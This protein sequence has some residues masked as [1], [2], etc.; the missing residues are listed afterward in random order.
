[1]SEPKFSIGQQVMVRAIR[2]KSDNAVIVERKLFPAGAW[3]YKIDTG[4]E[5]TLDQALWMYRFD[6]SYIAPGGDIPWTRERYIY[7]KHDGGD[8][9]HDIMESLKQLTTD[10]VMR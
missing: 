6:T 8:S 10:G 4:E 7:P 5:Y 3:F 2:F 9:F 1:M